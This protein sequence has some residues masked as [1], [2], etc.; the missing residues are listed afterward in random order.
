MVIDLASF[1]SFDEL[2]GYVAE[3]TR[4]QVEKEPS[5]ASVDQPYEED[6]MEGT[7]A[8]YG[9]YFEELLRFLHSHMESMYINY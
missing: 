1:F 7:N 6:M 8:H 2:F 3:K 9:F 5:Q 4:P